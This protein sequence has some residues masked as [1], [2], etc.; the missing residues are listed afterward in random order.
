[1]CDSGKKNKPIILWQIA[2]L[3]IQESFDIRENKGLN[4]VLEPHNVNS[5]HH[6]K[7]AYLPTTV[8]E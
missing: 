2:R 8:C 6:L 4:G 5:E 3:G 1:M 7:K